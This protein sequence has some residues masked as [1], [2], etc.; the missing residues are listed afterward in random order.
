MMKHTNIS[1]ISHELNIKEKQVQAVSDLLAEGSTIPFIARYR[2]E[3]TGSLDEVVVT[4]IRDRIKQIEELFKRKKAIIKTLEK[5]SSLTDDL[6]LKIESA[7]DI[8]TL[9]DIYLPYKQK[10]KTRAGKAKEKGLAPLAENILDQDN[11][12]P[13]LSAEKYINKDLGIENTQDAISGAKDILAELIS[14]D[15]KVRLALRNLFSA[16]SII[17]SSK[18]RKA[19]KEDSKN[20][21]MAKFT[22]YYEWEEAAATAP[23]HRILAMFRGENQGVLS[24][25]VLPDE[26][27]AIKIVEH[28]Y[29]KGDSLKSGIVK[30]AI[31]DSYKRLLSKSMG[32]ELKSALKDRAD[33][34]AIKKFSENLRQL[35]LLAPLGHKK[36][37][38]ID[39]GFRTGCKVVCLNESGKLF[40]YE[41]IYPFASPSK[42]AAI[43][44]IT[45]LCAEYDIEAIAIGNGTAGRETEAFIKGLSLPT[46]IKIVLVN[47]SGASI[48]SAS[49]TA[50][51]EF[52]DLDL[53]VRG[54]VSIGRRLMDPLAELVKI[55]PKSIGVGQYQHDVN[56]IRLKQALDDVVTSCVNGVGVD[57]NSA[58]RELLTYVS[59]IGPVLA[60]NIINF[61]NASGSFNSRK[62]LKKVPRFGPKAFE[63]SAGFLRITN[64]KNIL[65]S[66]AVHPESYSIVE[67][68]AKDLNCETKDLIKNKTLRNKID[69]Q[70]YISDKAGLPTLKDILN[71]LE[72]PGRDPRDT[73]E[74]FSF[75]P[76]INKIEDLETGM[77]LPGIVTNITAFGA[78]V[79]IGVHQ[80]GLVHIS[81]MADRFIKDPAEVVKLNQAVHVTVIDVDVKRKRIS[82]SMK[83]ETG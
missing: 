16:K 59:G 40:H 25:A 72:K 32:N 31:A 48:Y 23:S 67:K 65:D 46:G 30:Q 51:K 2:K 63:Q 28:F 50:R 66:T 12:D 53:T 7:T 21:E 44:S 62:D 69:I 58:S 55:D 49:E 42:E 57:L 41:T 4:A 64:G 77:K 75:K 68:M 71:E 9:E 61:R 20:D 82:L 37:M 29:I 54:A 52:P 14:E 73:F 45:S 26:T 19:D 8:Q 17:K 79:D 47:E 36:I 1:I 38:G 11:Q 6:Q 35:L 39:P 22:N 81:Q 56:Q 43:K 33:T 60:E 70:R 13:E 76:G 34:E 18:S 83:Q 10:K 78:F 15:E 5:N 3:K 74:E 80:D 24:L 27:M